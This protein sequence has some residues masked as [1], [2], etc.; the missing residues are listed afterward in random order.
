[1]AYTLRPQNQ[2]LDVWMLQSYLYQLQKEYPEIEKAEITGV[3]T[4]NTAAAIRVFQKKAGLPA[5]G[6]I[7]SETWDCLI[8]HV[9][10]QN[11]IFFEPQTKA[12]ITS[13]NSGLAVQK[14]QHYLNVLLQPAVLLIEDGQYGNKTT[15]AI[16]TFQKINQL[17]E[18][19]VLDAEV[20]N[21]VIADPRIG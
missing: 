7:G 3:Y 10:R 4:M 14:F 5:D 11:T 16:R 18:T 2:G 19:G 9:K 12:V 17:E 8:H 20:W 21:R 1:M 6:T 15:Q 13:G